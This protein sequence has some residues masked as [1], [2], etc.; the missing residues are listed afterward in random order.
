MTITV[1]EI[2]KL[3]I[4]KNFKIVAGAKGLTNEVMKIG[5]LDYETDELIEKNFNKG[6]FAITTLVVI[7]DDINELYELVQ[8][9]ISVGVC[10]LGIKNIYFNEIPR[11]VIELA[12]NNA[13]PIMIYSEAFF[14]DIVTSVTDFIKEKGEIDA[15]SLKIDNILYSNLDS[16]FIKKIAYE[17]NG[18]FREKNMV[19]YCKRVDGKKIIDAQDYKSI[20]ENK[21]LNKIIPYKEGFL[22]INTFKDIDYAG[23][24]D[25]MRRRLLELGIQPDKYIIGIS[26]LYEKLGELNF[27]IKESLY[28]YKYSSIYK[29]E[30]S[31]FRDIGTSKL[32]LPLI[33]NPWILKYHDE[34]IEPLIVYDNKYETELLKTAVVYIQN[35][36]D[37]KATALSLYQHGNTIRYRVNKISEILNGSSVNAHFYEELS[38]AIRIYNI[39]NTPL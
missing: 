19:A 12:E 11:N 8:R 20:H 24:A 23:A 15:I 26:S 18:N 33:D 4:F 3:E 37:I 27:S 21:P 10:G 6:D 22:F 34:M 32:L 38:M 14:E 9:M 5:I 13:F 16:V 36:G 1:N 35:N 7:K 29:R 17:I 28:A 2:L 39:L 30:L 31:F 25:I